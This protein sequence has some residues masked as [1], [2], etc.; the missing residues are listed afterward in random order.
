[1]RMLVVEDKILL[2]ESDSLAEPH[3]RI[4]DQ[5]DQPSRLIIEFHALCLNGSEEVDR[6]WL[7]PGL[8]R[9][10]ILPEVNA[11]KCGDIRET[12]F[13]AGEVHDRPHDA[14]VSLDARLAQATTSQGIPE[15][16]CL[17]SGIGIDRPIAQ[18][19]GEISD[20]T[21]RRLDKGQ[22]LS[23]GLRT[24][25]QVLGF[26]NEWCF[27]RVDHNSRGI[28]EK[29]RKGIAGRTPTEREPILL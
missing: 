5:C 21:V 25:V 28:T 3:A 29:P 6:N 15:L 4:A 14:H 18:E 9:D 13:P 7:A 17:L 20:R 26:R 1:M 11:H 24:Q 8:C 22:S 19:P 2:D 10:G 12:V 23:L 27:R 16:V